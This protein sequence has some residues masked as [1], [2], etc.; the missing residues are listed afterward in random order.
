MMAD[1]KGIICRFE[2]N[3]KEAQPL[4]VT[5]KLHLLCAHLVSFLKVDKSWGQVTEQGLESLHA[6]INSL[7]MRFVSVRNVE[8]NAESIVK[9]TGNFNFLYD[10]G[11]SWFTNI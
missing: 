5:P 11:K 1:M 2:A 3:H 8:K 10:L 7:I 4:T 9:H 6:V